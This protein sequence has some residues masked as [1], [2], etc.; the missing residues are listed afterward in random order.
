MSIVVTK[1]KRGYRYT[2]SC[3]SP[4]IIR[5]EEADHRENDGYLCINCDSWRSIESCVKEIRGESV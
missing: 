2:C 3:D 1:T 5:P 4:D